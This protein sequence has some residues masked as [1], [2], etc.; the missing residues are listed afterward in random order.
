MDGRA[1][2]SKDAP[3]CA[4]RR[5]GGGEREDLMMQPNEPGM[6]TL[7]CAAA[8]ARIGLAVAGLVVGA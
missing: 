4:T 2:K 6:E 1:Q 8:A 5:V 7:P 3:S